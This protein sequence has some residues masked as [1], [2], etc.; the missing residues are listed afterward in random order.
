VER[1]LNRRDGSIGAIVK[2]S[3]LGPGGQRVQA[4]RVTLSQ[5][6]D[7]TGLSLTQLSTHKFYTVSA[8]R[9]DDSRDLTP[10][11]ATTFSLWGLAKGAKAIQ[12]VE[13]KLELVIPDLDMH[14]V[15]VVD[16]VATR[17]GSPIDAPD[18]AKARVRLV[19]YDT[20]TADAMAKGKM[21]DG[22]QLFDGGNMFGP[23]PPG[24]PSWSV[25]GARPSEMDEDDIAVAISDPDSRLLSVEFQTREGL[26]IR[27]NHAGYY[28]SSEPI[29]HPESRFDVYHL[30]PSIPAGARLVC[31]VITDKSLVSIPLHMENVLLPEGSEHHREDGTLVCVLDESESAARANVEYERHSDTLKRQSTAPGLQEKIAALWSDIPG[32]AA[33]LKSDSHNETLPRLL[34]SVP[35]QFPNVPPLYPN[36]EISVLV[37]FVV[38]TGGNVEAARVAESN[39]PRFNQAA[40]GAVLKWNFAPAIMDGTPTEA[41]IVVPIRFDFPTLGAAAPNA[42]RVP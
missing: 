40:V 38:G 9:V 13:G 3:P 19:V 2:L 10:R 16:D 39:D 6:R 34:A 18:L 28:H 20:R 24:L 35:P 30:A 26:P 23:P 32:Y 21:P 5:A 4:G 14:S 12:S 33:L 27:Y 8:G 1:T 25:T 36:R 22:P 17:Y 29:G 41:F 7:D 37:S 11:E 42:A 15:V 31:H